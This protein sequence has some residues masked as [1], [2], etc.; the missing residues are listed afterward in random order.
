[1]I[2]LHGEESPAYVRRV[3]KRWPVIKAF[4]V[5]PRFRLSALRPY[6]KYVT[7]FLLDGKTAGLR[8]G[9]GKQ[10]DWD[11]AR[12]ARKYGT[13]FLAGGLKPEN[14]REAIRAARPD[15]VDVA[16][17]VESRPGKKHAAKLRKF[18]RE[19]KTANQEKRTTK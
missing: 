13:I 5:G 7:A 17:G 16:S 10:F 12:Q 18:F 11:I 8:G 2:Q 14:V 15:F 6:Q 9:T 19:V 4:R 3:A 1:M